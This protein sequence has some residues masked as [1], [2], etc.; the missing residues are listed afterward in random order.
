MGQ[1]GIIL[2][3]V[4]GMALVIAEII[5]PGVVIGLVGMGCMGSAIWLAFK[6]SASFGWTLVVIALACIP[7]MAFLY[8][9]VLNRFFV[10]SGTQKGTSG[11]K[12]QP[13]DLVG[14]EGVALTP[15]RPA[16]TARIGERKVDVVSDG[17]VIDPGTRVRVI[18]VKGNRVVVRAV[19][20]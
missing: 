3:Y 6:Q 2:L 9:K 12:V 7:V 10:M 19:G 17:E 4:A 14:Q 15:L 20:G 11:A 5:L 8:I 18:E 16:G 13:K 1:L